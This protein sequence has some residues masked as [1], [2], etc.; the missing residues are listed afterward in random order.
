MLKLSQDII[1]D[2]VVDGRTLEIAFSQWLEFQPRYEKL[3]RYYLGDHDF[4]PGT[5]AEDQNRIVSNHCRYITDVLVGYQYGNEPRYHCEDGDLAGEEL[6]DIMHGQDKW[7]VDLDVGLDLSIFGRTCELVYNPTDKDIPNSTEI[8]PMHGFVAYTG[9]VEKDSVFGVVVYSY[10]NNNNR[11]VYRLYVYDTMN[12]SVWETEN[13]ASSP[14]TWRLVEEPVPHGFGR[15]PLIEY[16]NNRNAL[17]DFEGIIP[18]QDAY[19]SLLSDR[20]DNQDSFAQ[21]MLV[22]TGAVMGR[23]PE[24]MADSKKIL[25][26]NAILQ[27]DEDSVA[28]YLTKQTDEAG[29]ELI[30]SRFHDDICRFS[31]IPDLSDEKFAGNASGVAMAYKL[32]GTDQVVSRKQSQVQKGFTRRCKLYDYRINNPTMNPSYTPVADIDRMTIT[33]NLNAPQD[34]S[35]IASALSQLTGG[36]KILSAETAR[37]LVSAIPDPKAE[38]ELVA[39]ESEEDAARMRDTFDYDAVDRLPRRQ[40]ED[41]DAEDTDE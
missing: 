12:F 26:K 11:T 17:S 10:T 7:S 1:V 16:K 40:A 36:A 9:T 21:A 31:M 25:K 33:F 20:Q 13:A 6:I 35:Y 27:L 2:P 24:E 37:T 23:T 18:L 39:A 34:I 15:V 29:V 22:L 30:Q 19:N 41:E 32:F 4:D 3:R 14:R 8:D 5:H 38:N 28:Q